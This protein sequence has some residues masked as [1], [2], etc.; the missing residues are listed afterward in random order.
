MGL[1][2]ALAERLVVEEGQVLTQSF[3]DY[4]LL[5]AEDM[6]G[7][8]VRLVESVDAQGPFGAKGLGESGVIAVSAAVANAVHDAIGIRFRELPITAARVQAA[9]TERTR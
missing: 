3:M 7:I 2:Y 8:A 1:G 6:P 4:A 9:L 5:R